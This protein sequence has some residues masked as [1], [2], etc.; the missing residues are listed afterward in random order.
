[1]EK[2]SEGT[3]Q[4]HSQ[5]KDSKS[6][7]INAFVLLFFVIVISAILTYIMPA[8]EY[9]RVEKDGRTLVVPDSFH[10]TDSSPVG[11]FDIF[12]SI[13]TGM[14]NGAGI[15][16]FILII[17]GAFGI[18]KTT[19]ALDA[20]IIN[21]TSKLSNR[22][23]LLIPVLMLFFGIGGA[24]M[25]MAEET[26][27]YIAIITPLAMALGLD[28]IVG[29]AIVSVGAN[30]GFMSA[31]LNP[32]N[33]GVAQSIA[34]LPTF[35]GI[36]L[37]LVLFITLY[38]AGVIFVYRY[39]RKIKTNPELRFNGN[40]QAGSSVNVDTTVKLTTRHKWILSIFL[41]NFV[42]LIFG[43][44][45]FGWYI[46]E[47]ASLFLLFGIII[48]VVGKLSP[49]KMADSFIDGAKDLIGGALIIGFAQAILVVIQDGKLIDSVLFYASTLLSQLSP[50]LN[51][52]GMFFLQL[53]LNFLVPSGSGQAALTMPIMAPLADLVGVTRQTAVLAFQ[54]GDGISNAIF[55]TSG[56]LL[57]GLAVA[58]I[59]YTKWIKWVLP[60]VFI[61]I[62]I[63]ILFLIIA[64]VIQY[65]PF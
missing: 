33:I 26:I 51:A 40:D 30:I 1:M 34:E 17:G 22:E 38:L 9:D 7:N 27:V 63:A 50:I 6:L 43:V 57:A 60:L 29:F 5:Q 35:S 31:V 23:L 45:K 28:A 54:L 61:Q 16:F 20:L 25:G 19:G 52:I 65:G 32:F 2:N 13:H 53:S 44:I 8:G 56:T 12:T 4:N 41:L 15:I 59:P 58:G 42:V 39:A 62:V 14:V 64:Q 24:L 55:P 49:N 47:I 46:T 37:R 3:H 11:F 48:G 10:L 18:L 21:I 36:G